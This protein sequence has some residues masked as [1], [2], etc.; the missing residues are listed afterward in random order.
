MT[1]ISVRDVMISY[2]KRP[3][4]SGL[5]F[6]VK[7]GDYLCIVG[8][9]GSG[10]TTLMKGL[11]G[12]LPLKKG[13]ICYGDGVKSSQIGYLPQQ[14]LVQKDFPASVQ[15]VVLS[16]CLNRMGLRPFFAGNEKR[17]AAEKMKELGI[18]HLKNRSYKMLSGGQ[19]QRVLLARALCAAE[20]IIL[21]DEPFSGLD[22][23]VTAEFYKI[24]NRLNEQG[25]TV[26]MI[27]HDVKAAAEYGG[28]ILHLGATDDFFGTTEEY[29]RSEIGTRFLQQEGG[30]QHV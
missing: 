13:E 30:A 20:K 15:E 16:G 10:K 2:E 27:T 25:I 5:S 23:I 9:N 14:T 19:Q 29:R 11:L 8:E 18:D 3:V 4:I 22:P 7:Q 6:D 1:Q 28:K 26:L 24:I 12:L 17:R 21:L